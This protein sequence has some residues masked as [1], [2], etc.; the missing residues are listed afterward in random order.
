MKTN[1]ATLALLLCGSVDALSLKSAVDNK[2]KNSA[3]SEANMLEAAEQMAMAS[4][5]AKAKT[6]AKTKAKAKT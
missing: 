6:K 2:L 5:H 1:I 4:A 3:L